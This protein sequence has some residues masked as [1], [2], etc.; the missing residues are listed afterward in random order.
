[1][2]GKS[3]GLNSSYVLGVRWTV[4]AFATYSKKVFF[5]TRFR[6][7]GWRSWVAFPVGRESVWDRKKEQ[8]LPIST[9]GIT[10]LGDIYLPINQ[11]L[12]GGEQLE[13]GGDFTRVYS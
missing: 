4:I 11:G 10:N 5:K 6:I 2:S 1:M 13:E 12:G 7:G 8:Q 9:K 3:R